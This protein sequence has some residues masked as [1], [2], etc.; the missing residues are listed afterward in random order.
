MPDLALYRAA[1]AWFETRREEL[2]REHPGEY[3]LMNVRTMI[4]Y[5]A[6]THN[7]AADKLYGPVP[8]EGFALFGIQLKK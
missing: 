8:F 3:F 1:E 5:I 7:E 6:P 4:F 2:T